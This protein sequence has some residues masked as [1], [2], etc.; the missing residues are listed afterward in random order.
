M[1]TSDLKLAQID[2]EYK[3]V[4]IPVYEEPKNLGAR[5]YKDLFA[6]YQNI[7][8]KAL[9]ERMEDYKKDLLFAVSKNIM[10]G[11]TES[12]YYYK[13]GHFSKIAYADMEHAILLI[14]SSAW[15]EFFSAP[16]M[17]IQLLKAIYAYS[18]ANDIYCSK[19]VDCLIDILGSL[20]AGSQFRFN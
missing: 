11:E 16:F 2:G 17:C 12:A 7:M 18:V 14:E 3:L 8:I 15:N 5:D 4:S 6:R 1:K 20:A 19:L 10:L 9:K 13:G